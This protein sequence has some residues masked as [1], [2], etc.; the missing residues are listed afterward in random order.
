[1]ADACMPEKFYKLAFPIL[2]PEKEVGPEGGRRP[3]DHHTVLKVIWFVLVTGCRWKDVPKEMGCCGETARTRMQSWEVAGIWVHLH[4]LLLSMLNHE[5][6]LHLET[7][8]VDTTHVRAFGGGESTGPSPVDRRKKGTKFTLLVDRYGVPLVVRAVPANRSD[9]LEILPAVLDFPELGGKPGRPLTHPKRLYA[10][11]GF[12]C[13]ATR[14]ILRWLGIDPHIRHRDGDHGS[15]LGRV[16][17]VVERTISWIKGLRRMRYRYDRS[18][19]SIDAWISIAAAV[20][21]LQIVLEA[22]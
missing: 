1:M 13:E 7:V 8:V 9:Q 22:V 12:D 11:A 21:C 3:K 19:T 6:Q 16:R 4:K 10:D 2:P 17:W 20:V 14:A 5:R 15:H 18:Q